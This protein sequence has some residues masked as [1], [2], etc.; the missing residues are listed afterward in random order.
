MKPSDEGKVS[1]CKVL[2]FTGKK[3]KTPVEIISEKL[4][5]H[6]NKLNPKDGWEER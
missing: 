1:T 4:I 5:A 6:A 2:K 3:R